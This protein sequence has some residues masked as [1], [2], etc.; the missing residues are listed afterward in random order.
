MK[1]HYIDFFGVYL[2]ILF[3]EEPRSETKT[4]TGK[5]YLEKTK[6]FQEGHDNLICSFSFSLLNA[7][8]KAITDFELQTKYPRF[9]EMTGQLQRLILQGIEEFYTRA[10]GKY[11]EN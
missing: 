3:K 4:Y 7:N 5:G 10:S 6:P 11:R 2:K 1:Y 9:K 8:W